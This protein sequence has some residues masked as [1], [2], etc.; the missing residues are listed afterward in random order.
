MTAQMTVAEW[1]E[2]EVLSDSTEA[3]DRGDKFRY[4]RACPTIREYVLI[5]TRYQAVDVYR[6]TEHG[7]E[8]R[9]PEQVITERDQGA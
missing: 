5:A 8:L 9:R 1:R 2:V 6:R 3:Y 4:Y 7:C